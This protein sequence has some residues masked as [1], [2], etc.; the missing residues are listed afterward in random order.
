MK[1]I[2]VI[3]A[4]AL[5][6]ALLF[7]CKGKKTEAPKEAAAPVEETTVEATPEE[8]PAPAPEV[9]GEGSMYDIQTSKGTIRVL[10]YDDTPLH[11]MN[12][13]AL[14]EEGFYDGILFHRVIKD[15]MIQTGDPL[16]K[17]PERMGEWGTGGP[18]YTI[19]AEI[20]PEHTHKK[21]ALAAARRGD[22]ANPYRESS[23]SQFYIVHNPANCVHL[24]GAYTVFGETVS[25]FDVI[26]KIAN[27][28]TLRS[29]RPVEDVKII[30]IVPVSTQ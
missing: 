18:G 21:G 3:T 14:V 6:A 24:D 9:T 16:T 25:G 27:V 17:D 10:L 11:K 4:L 2:L 13:E 19:P 1:R 7:S 26:D 23:G 8:T 12:F 15:F 20:I 22:E 30:K 28:Q 29:D 5:A